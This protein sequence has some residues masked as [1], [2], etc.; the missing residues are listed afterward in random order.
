MLLMLFV[1]L[2][3]CLL[4]VKMLHGHAFCVALVLLEELTLELV[5]PLE[6]LELLELELLLL[7]SYFLLKNLQLFAR[8][9]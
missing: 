4:L 1:V 7:L 9:Q 3:Y 8:L 2:M 6:L 5:L